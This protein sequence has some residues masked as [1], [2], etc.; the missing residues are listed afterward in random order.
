MRSLKIKCLPH[1]DITAVNNVL[2]VYLVMIYTPPDLIRLLSVLS[3]HHLHQHTVDL[4]I[5]KQYL[6]CRENLLL[7]MNYDHKSHAESI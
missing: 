2:T 1:G 6:Q 7:T 4:Y 5:N 3:F